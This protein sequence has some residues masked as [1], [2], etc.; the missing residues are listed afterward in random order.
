M[1]ARSFFDALESPDITDP[2]AAY[3]VF[4]LLFFR[5]GYVFK[6]MF[7]EELVFIIIS[8]F[9]ALRNRNFVIEPFHPR[10]CESVPLPLRV[11][12]TWAVR[13]YC[14]RVLSFFPSK[15]KSRLRRRYSSGK[16][17][18]SPWLPSLRFQDISYTYVHYTYIHRHMPSTDLSYK[19]CVWLILKKRL[20]SQHWQ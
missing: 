12:R 20:R 9:L 7:F 16:D 4:M 8:F 11:I 18:N 1:A 17:S 10:R 19:S 14:R 13:K 15:W 2:A 5:S 3:T 6:L